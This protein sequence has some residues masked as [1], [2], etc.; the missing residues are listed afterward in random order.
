MNALST[1]VFRDFLQGT[2]CWEDVS[3]FRATLVSKL[4]GWCR[5]HGSISSTRGS[6]GGSDSNG[7]AMLVGWLLD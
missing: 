4:L 6:S 1:V 7:C 3:E 5:A 2:P